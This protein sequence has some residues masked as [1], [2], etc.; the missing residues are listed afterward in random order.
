MSALPS[1]TE[2]FFKW[3]DGDTDADMRAGNPFGTL[4]A[5]IALGSRLNDL[6]DHLDGTTGKHDA[7]EVDYERADGSKK[8]I[9]AASDAV[10]AALTDLDDA[11]YA[12][13]TLGLK[14]ATELTIAAGVIT[15]TQAFHRVDT[16]ADAASD[17]VDTI[18]ASTAGRIVFLYPENDARSVVIKHGTGNIQCVAGQDIT[19]AE[20]DDVAMAIYVRSV[21]VCMSFKTLSATGS[22]LG[23]L[24]GALASLSTTDKSTIVASI[25]EVVTRLQWNTIADPGNAGAIPVTVSGVCNLTTGGAGETRTI[26][27]PT[28][29]G[30]RIGLNLN[31]DGGGDCVVTFAS[32]INVDGDT[33]VTLNDAGEYLEV[34][35][36]LIAAALRWREVSDVER[37]DTEVAAAQADATQALPTT[38]ADPGNGNAIAVTRSGVCNLTTGGAGETRTLA[39][40]TFVG[41][42][43]GLNLDVDGGGDCVITVASAFNQDGDTV[44]TLGDVGDYVELVGARIA[45]A[46]RWREAS[47]VERVDTEVAAAALL[48][49]NAQTRVDTYQ[50]QLV[51]AVIT[52]PDVGGG[53][54]DCALS[55]AVRRAHDAATPVATL[56]QLFITASTLQYQP[57]PPGKATVTFAAATVGTLITSGSG[58]ALIQTDAVGAFACTMANSADETLYVHADT[59]SAP[60]S[61]A[62][63]CLVVG[64]VADD[65]TW[66]A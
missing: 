63:R 57:Y 46:L 54:T 13:P 21:W 64:A 52:A 42:R 15:P 47:D 11:M 27:N 37:V 18:T 50:D 2:K 33:V 4:A 56:C 39:V 5:D 61:L 12:L 1:L 60:S 3:L 41:Q 20:D 25:N 55:I 44:I 59:A 40:A 17:D 35:A 28:F 26:A 58:W 19:L 14:A 43:L 48:G 16:Q 32:G 65:V 8:F 29:L 38:I 6:G 30:Q 51:V 31:V 7:T 53:G 49:T 66:S 23:A 62:A 10:E 9:Q 34:S 24:I 22:G 36:V 45:G